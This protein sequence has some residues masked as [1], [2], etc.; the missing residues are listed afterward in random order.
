MSAFA[1]IP[2]TVSR[3]VALLLAT[4]GAASA[5]TVHWVINTAPSGAGSLAAAITAASGTTTPQEIRFAFPTNS[6]VGISNV[7]FLNQP[8]PS[9]GG[10]N[11]RIDGSDVTAGVIIDGGGHPIFS[12]PANANTAQLVLANLK[13]Q[14]GGRIGRGGCVGI[15]G[16]GVQTRVE[17]VDFIDCR[18]YLDVGV[19]ARGGALYTAGALQVSDSVFRGN[20]VFNLAAATADAD[21]LGGAIMV[22]TA[23]TVTITRSLFEDNGVHLVNSLPSF[24][25]SGHGGA[26]ALAMINDAAA[27]VSESSFLGNRNTCRHPTIGGDQ[28]GA[29]DGGGIVLY[30]RGTYRIRGNYFADNLGRRGGGLLGDQAHFSTLRITNNTFVGNRGVASGG[31]V[32]VINCCQTWLDHNTFVGNTGSSFYGSQFAITGSPIMSIRYNAMSGDSPTC[33]QSFINF[34]ENVD[35]NAYSDAGCTLSG[36]TNA[37][38]NQGPLPLQ[39]PA[40]LGGEVL[41]MAPV[42]GSALIDAGPPDAPCA[43]GYDVRNTPRPLDGNLDGTPSCDIG[44]VESSYVPPLTLEIFTDGFETGTN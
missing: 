9:L 40:M 29:G 14:R 4:A 2:R 37:I 5:Q 26:I 23:L 38:A 12:L 24:C 25:A 31:G 20:R 8:L 16:T 36:E 17:N 13:L 30:G 44:A 22:S 15:E 43:D 11:L 28:P 1:R 35:R 41:S 21:A 27:T 19:P 39:S 18:A 7:I 32:G 33:S 10:A 6:P 3:V 42:Y 34:V